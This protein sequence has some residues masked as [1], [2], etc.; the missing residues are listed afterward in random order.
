M[1]SNRHGSPLWEQ[2]R[3]LLFQV[4]YLLPLRTVYVSEPLETL[5]VLMRFSRSV[6]A[7]L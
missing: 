5:V 1:H 7:L 3:S 4:S 2:W 6:H